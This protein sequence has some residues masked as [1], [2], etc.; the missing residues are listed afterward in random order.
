MSKRS[1]LCAITPEVRQAVE[2]RDGFRCIFCGRPGRGEAHVIG[3]AQG[4]LGIEQ[5]IVTVCRSC[6]NELDNGKSTL[7]YKA[8]ARDYLKQHYPFYDFETVIYHK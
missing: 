4:G 1:K 5:N 6:H 7:V 3:R 8:M 2:L